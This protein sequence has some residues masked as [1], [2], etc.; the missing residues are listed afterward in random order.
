MQQKP[1][2]RMTERKLWIAR[3]RA[4]EKSGWK[5]PADV[6]RAIDALIDAVKKLSAQ[7]QTLIFQEVQQRF[8]SIDDDS[9][10]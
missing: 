5:I 8:Y 3:L 7:E 6:E 9:A 2:R 1:R 4:L 10:G